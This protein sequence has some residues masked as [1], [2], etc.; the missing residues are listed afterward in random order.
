MPSVQQ[1]STE[2]LPADPLAGRPLQNASPALAA[3][4]PL[5]LIR[6]LS[7]D[8]WAVAALIILTSLVAW[9]RIWFWDGLAYLDVATFYLPWYAHLGEAIRS[10]DIPGWNPYVFSGTPFAGDPQS[11]WAYLPAMVFFMFL[12]PVAAYQWMLVFHLL[13]AALST[14][15]FGRQLGLRPLSAVTAAAAYAF[16]PLVNH[17]SCCLIHVQL[18]VWIPPALIGVELS[19]RATT[20]TRRFAGWTITGFAIS[21]MLAGWIGQGAYNGL[22]VVG[23]YLL[24]RTLCSPYQSAKFRARARDTILSGIVV[25][26]IGFGLGA[27]G[28][29]RRLDAVQGTNVA[30]GQYTGEGAV[31]Y[32][33]GWSLS[34]LFDRLF[35]DGHSYFTAL[36]YLGGATLT[37]AIMAVVLARRRYA[38]PYFFGLLVMTAILSLETITPVHRLFYLLPRFEALHEHVPT[39]VVAVQWIAPAMLAG[40][41]VEALLAGSTTR[42]LRA[43]GGLALV[44]WALVVVYLDAN[45]RT[46][47]IATLAIVVAIALGTIGLSLRVVSVRP[48]ARLVLACFVLGAAVWEPAGRMFTNAVWMGAVDPVLVLPVGSID[49]DATPINAASTDPGG[50][51][52]FLQ[53]R[54]ADGELFRYYGYDPSYFAG[55]W[56]WPSTYRE[57]YWDRTVQGL[58]VNARAMRLHLFDVQG[59]NPVQLID[60]VGTFNA[61]NG[62]QQDYHDA[63]V[64]EGGINSPLLDMLNVRYIVIPAGTA[65]GRTRP[66]LR[67]LLTENPEVFRSDTVRVLENPDALPRAWLVHDAVNASVAF[68]Q[69]MIRTGLVNPRE[70]AFLE[71]GVALPSLSEPVNSTDEQ[72]AVTSYSAD[73]IRLSVTSTADGLLV[74]SEVYDGGWSAYIDGKRVPIERANGVLRAVALPSGAHEVEFRYSPASLRIG[75]WVTIGTCILVGA[76]LLGLMILQWGRWRAD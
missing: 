64:W 13:L 18:A 59:Y 53:E 17:I 30:G 29:L 27:A 16:G 9:Q 24:Y 21:Q 45:G 32:S 8:I 22:L 71:P 41:A 75:I 60:Y 70:I 52:E 72:V 4:R 3:R 14:Y 19:A 25:L 10:F 1:S 5:L 61:I 56:G 74:L 44:T 55:G 73:E 11:G 65:P 38:T 67:A 31:D 46:I 40:A 28:L 37:L 48:I 42:R 33:R 43:A 34:L 69:L 54:L 12:K 26:A 50:A 68:A 66:D 57:F 76:L 23:T 47:G 7:A 51:G 20:G 15:V 49:R 58:L 36:F 35:G 2:A 6:S 39:R 63:Q 62:Q